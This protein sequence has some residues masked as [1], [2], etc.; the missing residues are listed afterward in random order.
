MD[1]TIPPTSLWHRLSSSGRILWKEVGA[2]GLIGV[3][4]LAIDL[5]I[6]G[7]LAPHGAL[8]AKCISTL[9]A[10]VFSYL[11]N[12]YFS[13]SHRARSSIARETSF[14]FLINLIVLVVSELIIALFVYPLHY[15]HGSGVVFWVNFLT[16]GLG[17]IFRFWSYK[18]FVFLHPDKVHDP[19][20][21]IDLDAE[22]SE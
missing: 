5:G 17:T 7:W 16:I 22:L 3:L 21:S 18:R 6:F 10:M 19:V 11:G 8:K 12:R 2:F 15:S 14:F 13:F 20:E 4:G 9:V 1:E